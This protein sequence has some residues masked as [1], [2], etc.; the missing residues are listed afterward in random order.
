VGGGIILSKMKVSKG[1]CAR[2]ITD[3]LGLDEDAAWLSLSDS[4]ITCVK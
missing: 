1:A 2:E 4:T 3:A